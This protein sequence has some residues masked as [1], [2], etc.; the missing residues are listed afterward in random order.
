[1]QK[2]YKPHQAAEL[3]QNVITGHPGISPERVRQL[4]E[5]GRLG[6]RVGKGWIIS[7]EDIDNFN[8]LNR[9]KGRPIKETI[10]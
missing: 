10:E 7:Q 4:C 9:S 1:M 2:L 5:Q 8:S 3:L 6:Q